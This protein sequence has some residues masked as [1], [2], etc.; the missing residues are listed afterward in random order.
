MLYI[1]Q[2]SEKLPTLATWARDQDFI[3]ENDLVKKS[4]H[5]GPAPE[6][7]QKQSAKRFEAIG[8][9]RGEGLFLSVELVKD[10]ATKEPYPALATHIVN[11]IREQG[12]LISSS[13][14]AGNSLKIR[15]LL[16]FEQM[17]LDDLLTGLE[18]AFSA[19]VERQ[20]KS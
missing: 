7:G 10:R 11:H 12:I 5:E 3:S 18:D 14:R 17:H 8:D 2:L 1:F 6:G 4:Q 19:C 16:T 9:V 15:P 20:D 13:G